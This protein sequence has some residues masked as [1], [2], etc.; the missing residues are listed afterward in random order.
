MCEGEMHLETK[1]E[2]DYLFLMILYPFLI[3]FK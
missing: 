3:S 2:Q 1:L